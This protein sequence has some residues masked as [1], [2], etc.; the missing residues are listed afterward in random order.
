[1]W[2]LAI[3]PY[4]MPYVIWK[5]ILNLLFIFVLGGNA[6]KKRVN[7]MNI[8][9][10]VIVP[11][12]S[13]SL[14]FGFVPA[15]ADTIETTDYIKNMGRAVCE[16]IRVSDEGLIF[17]GT[18][19][20]S[21]VSTKNGYT[22]KTADSAEDEYINDCSTDYAFRRLADDEQK[23]E[24]LQKLYIRIMDVFKEVYSSQKDYE[25]WLEHDGKKCYT[26]DEVRF[27]DLGIDAETAEDVLYCVKYDHPLF[28]F[29]ENTTFNVTYEDGKKTILP[30]I[31]EEFCK[32][33]VRQEYNAKI[34]NIINDFE[35]KA[36]NL[37]SNKDIIKM[38]HDTIA[39]ELDY[40]YT[41]DGVTPK[42]NAYVHNI[43]CYVSGAKEAVCDG[44]T[45]TM[46]AVLN[47]L[48]VENII[49]T[50]WGKNDRKGQKEAHAWNLVRLSNGKY[51]FVDITWDDQ[52]YG[53]NDNYLFLGKELYSSHFL[54]NDNS[55]RDLPYPLPD[56]IAE[57]KHAGIVS[58]VIASDPEYKIGSRW[59]PG[60]SG[61]NTGKPDNTEAPN[62]TAKPSNT[63][64]PDNT[65]NNAG[66][67][68]ITE[69][70]FSYTLLSDGTISI[71]AY[72][73][74]DA[75]V[76]VPAKINGNTVTSIENCFNNND[77]VREITLP[78]TIYNIGLIGYGCSALEKLTINAYNPGEKASQYYS[79]TKGMF[80]NCPNLKTITVNENE[81]LKTLC[82][83]DNVLYMDEGYGL[84]LI[85]YPAG[86][87]DEKYT[88]SEYPASGADSNTGEKV[89]RIGESAFNGCRL[90][91]IVIPESV[92]YIEKS[93]FKDCSELEK[94]I[95]YNNYINFDSEYDAASDKI[96]VGCDKLTIYGALDSN[97]EKY[98]KK[99]EKQ[100]DGSAGL[101]YAPISS[102]DGNGGNSEDIVYSVFFNP[103]GGKVSLVA[104]NVTVGK[105]YNTLPAPIRMN[106][107][108]KGWYT[109]KSGGS[110]VTSSTKVNISKDQT[111]YARWAKVSVKKLTI[112]SVKKQK[113]NKALVKWK[114]VSG[115]KGYMV[116]Y[117]L[118]KKFKKGKKTVTVASKYSSKKLTKLKKRKVYYIKV[119]AYKLDS[120]K[121]RIY[122]K[123]A[124][125][126]KVKI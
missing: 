66:S 25:K 60:N 8:N 11:I 44:Y 64:T 83:Y 84:F 19:S 14:L 96:W 73:G 93:A 16:E 17:S 47:Y 90:K 5:K 15:S 62:N 78:D 104:K 72:T 40:A 29:I 20:K 49:V 115:A 50:G 122:G 91:E 67:T 120:A 48:D 59:S 33:S 106:Y 79:Y 71:T 89:V 42:D 97:I 36:Q 88:I 87:V 70:G 77:T 22:L 13:I 118:D 12:V 86:K 1:M 94:C 63:E 95:I 55:E 35:S 6:V 98:A 114:K 124:K 18:D 2:L 113:K 112:V 46:A 54:E 23:G 121:K 58:R 76:D 80:S 21:G 126:K 61:N 92:A 110:K 123:C 26:V 30:V 53:V 125:I 69:T 100:A 101:K 27:D 9:K 37:T 116:T 102:L 3:F 39:R 74:K 81:N 82:A 105:N 38:V 4:G 7:K 31:A 45:N 52:E 68:G 111:L 51:Y 103:N 75:V 41:E 28:Y 99:F 117:A 85:L 32:G 43:S 109:A 57:T 119:Q 108:F 65:G 24:A 107:I 10:K 34:K 56:E